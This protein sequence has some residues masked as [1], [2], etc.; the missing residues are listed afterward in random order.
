MTISDQNNKSINLNSF[1]L[2]FLNKNP[3]LFEIYLVI[4]LY[5]CKSFSIINFRL[6]NLTNFLLFFQN[7]IKTILW[8]TRVLLMR[9]KR[10][11]QIWG[12]WYR[13]YFVLML[14]LWYLWIVLCHIGVIATSIHLTAWF[15]YTVWFFIYI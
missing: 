9:N 3:L 14:R 10:M 2:I 4:I 12:D 13:Y 7:E 1:P 8:L 15:V 6:I 5:S 11:I